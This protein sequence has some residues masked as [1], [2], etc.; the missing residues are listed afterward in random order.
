MLTDGANSASQIRA[1]NDLGVL[2]VEDDDFTRRLMSRLLHDLKVRCLWEA[3][4]GMAALE[5]L[6]KHAGEVDVAICDLEM[7]RMS[8]LDL[9]HALRTATGN[10]LADLPVVV[11]T[12]HREADTVKRAIAYGISGYLVKPVSKADLIKRL[13]FVI[14]KG[15]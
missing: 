1:I 5:I 7:P 9:L 10:P 12:A 14:Q 11:L 15:R 8:G 3:S 4:D 6:R 2:L 13:S